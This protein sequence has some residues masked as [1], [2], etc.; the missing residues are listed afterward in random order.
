M[1]VV[2]NLMVRAGADFSAITKQANKAKGSMKSMQ[3]GVSKSCSVMKSAL[4]TLGVALSAAALVS[5]AKDAKSAYAEAAEADAKL[6][7]VMRNTMGASNDEIASI[8]ALASAQ[9]ALGVVGDDVQLAGAQEL[10]TYLELSDSLKTLIPV[11]NDM[12]AQ[13][14]GLNATQENAVNIATMLGKVMNGQTGALSRY[15]YSFTKAQEEVLKFGTEEQRAAVLAEVVED[16]VGGMNAALANTPSGRLQQLNNTLG[17]IK[18]NFGQAVTSVLTAFLP[19]LNTVASVL[20]AVAT[21]ANR[22]AQSI[23]NVFGQ[24]IGAEAVSYQAAT[25]GAA[26][27]MGELTKNTAAAGKAAKGLS[28]AGF[29][30]LQKLSKSSGSG[31]GESADMSELG[32]GGSV[33]AIGT[34]AQDAAEGIGSLETGLSKLK[35]AIAAVQES[36]RGVSDLLTGK[37]SLEDYIAQLSPLETVLWSIAGALGAIALTKAVEVIGGVVGA[38]AGLGAL[39]ATGGLIGGLASVFGMVTQEGWSLHGAMQAVFGPKSVLAGVASLVGGIT[40]AVLNFIGMWKNGFSWIKETL[41]VLGV[42]LGG[43]GAIILGA[44]AAVAAAIGGIIAAVATAVILLKDNW[45]SVKAD[46]LAVFEQF[47]QSVIDH[48]EAIKQVFTGLFQ[49]LKGLFTLNFPEMMAGVKNVFKGA[50]NFIISCLNTLISGINAIAFPLRALIVGIGK[51]LGKSFTLETV[52]IP[53]IPKL[54]TGAVI[55][56]NHEFAAILG[57]Q[58]SGRNIET[59]EKL[60]RQIYREESGSREVVS[61]LAQILDATESGKTIKINERTF[62]RLVNNVQREHAWA[63]G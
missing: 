54:A 59:P 62:G 34:G 40:V 30:T 25:A 15:G 63:N 42:A 55:Q 61:L 16:S 17:D 35:G 26:G 45:A 39:S 6:A 24:K 4:G 36:L 23:A 22:V 20:A 28:T 58:T 52:R 44:P 5:F 41:M 48:V 50:I 8:R 53:S 31:G 56:P 7:Q 49:I 13:Q 12:L 33:A 19:A 10:A 38:I 2:K 27:S 51:V 9:Q 57:D 37:I 47:K 3:S 46:A 21:L 1:P 29:D 60:L 32:T 14:Y 18:E 11:M 43:L